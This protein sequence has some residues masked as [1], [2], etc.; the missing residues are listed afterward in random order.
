MFD[1]R[2]YL[3]DGASNSK[4]NE[5]IS[6]VLSEDEFATQLLWDILISDIST[7]DMANFRKYMQRLL[8][9]TEL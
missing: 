7:E 2:L 6:K 4:I 1:L 8:T 3:L 9:D 5:H